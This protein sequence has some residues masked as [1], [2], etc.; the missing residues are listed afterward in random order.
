VK[1]HVRRCIEGGTITLRLEAGRV[2]DA[3][4]EAVRA[5]TGIDIRGYARV[6]DSGDIRHALRSHGGHDR[7]AKRGQA[8]LKPRDFALV[9]RIAGMGKVVGKRGGGGGGAPT[10]R[11]RARIGR[12]EYELVEQV[13]HGKRQVALKTLWKRRI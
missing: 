5:A 6:L 9:G 10:V 7:E 13:R 12:Y 1:R 3:N 11:Y 8:P 2:S 4:A